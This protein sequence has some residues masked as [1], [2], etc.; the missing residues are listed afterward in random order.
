MPR[1][2]FRRIEVMFPIEDPALKARIIDEILRLVLADN[3]K[4]RELA[5]DGTYFRRVPVADEPVVRSQVALQQLARGTTREPSDPRSVLG[6]SVPR[7]RAA[8]VSGAGRT[9]TPA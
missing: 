1:N 2:F 7:P 5:P 8:P 3:V 6:P 4:A 9:R